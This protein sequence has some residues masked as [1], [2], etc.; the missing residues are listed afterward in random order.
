MLQ[1]G[2]AI[3]NNQLHESHTRNKRVVEGAP[4]CMAECVS[5]KNETHYTTHFIHQPKRD[6]K[7][8]KTRARIRGD[9]RF[10]FLI[11]NKDHYITPARQNS[12]IHTLHRLIELE[13]SMNVC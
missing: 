9:F 1:C 3:G 13:Q 2:H 10:I 7:I 5:S 11:Q 4:L 12:K 6:A 8:T